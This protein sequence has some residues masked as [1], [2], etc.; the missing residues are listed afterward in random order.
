MQQPPQLWILV[1]ALAAAP[2]LG[3]VKLCSDGPSL[4]TAQAASA[5]AAEKVDESKFLRG[6]DRCP[7]LPADSPFIWSYQQG[8]DFGVCYGSRSGENDSAFGIYLG[9]FPSFNPEQ[10]VAIGPGKVAGY[11]VTW[12]ELDPGIDSAFSRQTL[13]TFCHD[14]NY[15]EAAHV[16]VNASN[17]KELSVSLSALERMSFK[18]EGAP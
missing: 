14:Q 16:W 7:T 3:Q 15:T 2:A 10:G 17:P 5:A 4:N 11:V 8:P 12:Y 9:N 6:V 13:V 18:N 1:L